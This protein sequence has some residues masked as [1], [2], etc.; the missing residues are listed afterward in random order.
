[1]SLFAKLGTPT[2]SFPNR[3]DNTKPA[4]HPTEEQ[5]AVIDYFRAHSNE[6]LKVTA[7]AGTGKTSTLIQLAKAIPGRGLYIAFN[8]QIATEA[9]TRFRNEGINNVVAKTSH[10]LAYVAM[11]IFNEPKRSLCSGRFPYDACKQALRGYP[12]LAKDFRSGRYVAETLA[13]FCQS[14]DFK[15][16]AKHYPEGAPKDH[17]ATLVQATA[18]LWNA[19]TDPDNVDVPILHDAYL[20]QWHLSGG[21]LPVRCDYIMFDEA[22]DANAVT[23][24]I[25]AAQR[26]SVIYI[27]D[28]H[29]QIYAFRGA[30]NAMRSIDAVEFSLT[31]S[32]RFGASIADTANV[33]LAAKPAGL[34]P[35]LKV[36]GNP[37]KR[38]SVHYITSDFEHNGKWTFLSRTNA[39][40]FSEA[41]ALDSKKRI[42]VVGGIE[43]F[44]NSVMT[45]RAL[46]RKEAAPYN[47]CKVIGRFPTWAQLEAYA[48]ATE[49][50]EVLG[51]V[52]LLQKRGAARVADDI[53]RYKYM[54]VDDPN[55]ADIVFSTA[56]KAKGLEWENVKLLNDFVVPSDVDGSKWY[57]MSREEREA[58]LNLLYVA[59]TRAK[60]ILF[61]NDAVRQC[62]PGISDVGLAVKKT[63]VKVA[64][65]GM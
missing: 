35:D 36:R 56:H 27:G 47:A 25:I 59:A 12:D 16:S 24:A 50:P 60:D 20:K 48:E 31:Q 18:N 3:M 38:S 4:M 43:E 57:A 61:I 5:Q 33:I 11:G 22:Q 44:C 40:I 37:N 39:R 51:I 45:A 2:L 19:M 58:E 14:D 62:V 53:E 13:N 63:S 6:H 64:G 9:E 23:L 17:R 26:K 41:M 8:K 28:A 21:G 32:F 10:S 34:V 30:V 52:R 42:H 46:M 65:L 54:H 1:M 29:Q 49:D 15:I 55:R 7:F